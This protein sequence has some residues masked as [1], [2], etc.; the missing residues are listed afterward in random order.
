MQWTMRDIVR[1][2]KVHLCPVPCQDQCRLLVNFW[3][4][5]PAL[6][7][8]LALLLGF[9]ASFNGG[10]T[11]LIP[12]LGLWT[13]FLFHYSNFRKPFVL[14]LALFCMAWS[15]ASVHYRFPKLPHEGVRGTAHISVQSMRLQRSFFGARWIY[16]CQIVNFFPDSLPA[17]SIAKQI[18][19]TIALPHRE[20]LIRPPADQDYV[21]FGTLLETEQGHYLLKVSSDS[22]WNKVA[23]SWNLAES[24][25]QWK[26]NAVQWINAHF[27]TPLSA[28]F[29][30]GLATG[31]FD[32]HW[33]RQEF[34]RFGLQHIMA[35]SG[36]H[37]AIIVG[38]L[39]VFIQSIASRKCTAWILLVC[40][41]GYAL[42]LGSNASI[43]RAWI[44]SSIVIVGYLLEKNAASLNSIGIAL[45]ATLLIDP[46]FSQTIGFQF[47]FL[48]TAAIL[49]VFGPADFYLCQILSKR[50]L[51]Q[52]VEMN[53]WNQH[54]YCI[55]AFFRKGLALLLAVNLFAIPMTLYYFHQFP[56]MSLLYNL[57]FPL[58][59]AISLGLLIFGILAAWIPLIGSWLNSFND[60]YTKIILKLTYQM[61]ANLDAYLWVEDFPWIGLVTYL[62]IVFLVV[63]LKREAMKTSDLEEEIVFV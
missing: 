32:D 33:L 57:F 21:V 52:V 59:I 7:Y 63:I 56:W 34:A 13:P 24:R 6:L 51:S 20:E 46:L 1:F 50:P 62:T 15:Y 60:L 41:A 42:F 14:S 45:M 26:K 61:P 53:G 38:I 23:G 11:I 2:M 8:G 30:G 49:L 10:M 40:M 44:M 9:F 27:Q 31:E 47:S 43:M 17:R 22:P 58:L 18:K 28:L 16:N 36:F 35:I 25:Y 37:F 4:L 54:G 12:C 39:S 5:H 55:L 3:H 29:L 48:T 19:C